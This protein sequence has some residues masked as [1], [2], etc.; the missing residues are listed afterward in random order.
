LLLYRGFEGIYAILF[1]S[2]TAFSGLKV[3]FL[4]EILLVKNHKKTLQ[5]LFCSVFY[6][7]KFLLLFIGSSR[8]CY[9]SH[10]QNLLRVPN[11]FLRGL[12]FQFLRQLH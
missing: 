5:K 11:W 6:K 1:I 9:L 4:T 8:P 10:H 2:L 3:L 12:H 7:K